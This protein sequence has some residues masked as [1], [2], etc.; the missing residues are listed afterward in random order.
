MEETK[1]VTDT[2]NSFLDALLKKDADGAVAYMQDNV[3]FLKLD[4][5][6]TR[7]EL[8]TSLQGYFDSASFPSETP[9]DVVDA[10]SMFVELAASPVEGV[11]G[12]VYVLNAK[13]KIDM[14][15][16]IPIWSTYQRY[17]FAKDG[18]DWKIF[19]LLL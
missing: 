8:K 2:F 16:S 9:A 11:E 1:A 14:S 6:V 15:A 18:N 7:E 4:Q 10:D 3:R 13:A 12:P 17:Y 19:A 5:T